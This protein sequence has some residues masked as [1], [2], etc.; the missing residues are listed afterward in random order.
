MNLLPHQVEGVELLLSCRLR[1]HYNALDRVRF[2]FDEPGLGK[3]RQVTTAL[4]LEPG[5][6]VLVVCPAGLALMWRRELARRTT[7]VVRVF[8]PWEDRPRGVAA[9]D[10][11]EVLIISYDRLAK[12]TLVLRPGTIVVFDEAQLAKSGTSKRGRAVGSTAAYALSIGGWIWALTGTPMQSSPLDLWILM[13]WLG[14]AD[15]VFGKLTDFIR[16]FGGLEDRFGNLHWPKQPPGGS[17]AGHLSGIALRRLRRDV[18]VDVPPKRYELTMVP[19]SGQSKALLDRALIRA[20]HAVGTDPVA[21]RTASPITATTITSTAL[22]DVAAGREQLASL[23]TPVM[24]TRIEA[25]EQDGRLVAV[26]SSHRAPIDALATRKGWRVITGDEPE[27]ARDEAVRMFQAGEL[28]GIGY[29]GA[30]SLGHTLTAADVV[31]VVSPPWTDAEMQQAED[32]AVRI[33]TLKQVVV[34]HLVAQHPF[35][36]WVYDVLGVKRERSGASVDTPCG[37][38]D[39]PISLAFM[40]DRPLSWLSHSR[41]E[42]YRDC[43]FKYFCKHDLDVEPIESMVERR[44]GALFAANMQ[45]RLT[46]WSLGQDPFGRDADRAAVEHIKKL[47]SREKWSEQFQD[48]ET[49]AR[50]AWQL[51]QRCLWKAGFSE[52]R[53]RP[54]LLPDG[55]PAVESRLEVPVPDWLAGKYAGVVCKPDLI[56]YDMSA[57]GRLTVV[58]FKVRSKKMAEAIRDGNDDPQL[59]LY[60]HVARQLGIRVEL[61]LRLEVLGKLPEPPKLVGKGKAQKLS[62]AQQNIVDVEEYVKA[63]EEHGLDPDDYAE[64][65]HWLRTAGPRIYQ[66]VS[67]GREQSALDRVFHELCIRAHYATMLTTPTRNLRIYP[68]SPC[69]RPGGCEYKEI[70]TAALPTHMDPRQYADDLVRLGK[71]KRRHDVGEDLTEP[72][73]TDQ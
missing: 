73:E 13:K 18:L 33:G 27:A 10:V 25:H 24:M 23:K 4:A 15:L 48:T 64:Y 35:D 70:C 65:V 66:W 11:G 60:M 50:I 2:I 6:P 36:L 61:A 40:A 38:E 12:S 43:H 49:A 37:P 57:S 26:Y 67:C 69:S 30:G 20:A 5:R 63:I 59:M 22:A 14:V 51:A 7:R 46:V 29:T 47:T 45:G 71:L 19:V 55:R 52:G 68:G 31:M 28:R 56:A 39:D 62:T 21:A 72:V 16:H 1:R 54:Y 17:L 58:D 44:L 8:G 34:E 3:T 9:P 32:R 41:D 53:W 42:L